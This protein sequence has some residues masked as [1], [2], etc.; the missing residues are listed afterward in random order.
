MA[1]TSLQNDVIMMS[2]SELVVHIYSV[3]VI[4]CHLVHPGTP[5]RQS[6]MTEDDVVLRPHLLPALL[7]KG[8]S[9]RFVLW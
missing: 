2:L 4:T 3:R 7:M 8:F 5:N 9:E 1:K 6:P